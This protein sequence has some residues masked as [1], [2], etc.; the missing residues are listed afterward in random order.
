MGT[1]SNVRCEHTGWADIRL[2]HKVVLVVDAPA[3]VVL[4]QT[5]VQTGALTAFV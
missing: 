3:V 2:C 5:D 1:M 4:V